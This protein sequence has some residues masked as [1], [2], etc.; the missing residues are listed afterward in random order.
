MVVLGGG[1]LLGRTSLLRH[2]G[3]DGEGDGLINM[4]SMANHN[5]SGGES[6]PRIRAN[7]PLME[8]KRGFAHDLAFG[9]MRCSIVDLTPSGRRVLGLHVF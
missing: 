3:P 7:L 1:D 2:R 6:D 9:Y 5:C 8:K 4:N